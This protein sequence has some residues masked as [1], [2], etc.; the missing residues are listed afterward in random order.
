M[1]LSTDIDSAEPAEG[2]TASESVFA[3]IYALILNGALRPGET[4]KES[5][6]SE[7]FNVSRGPVREAVN[8]L[9]GLGLV[10]KQAYGRARVSELTL[11]TV[12]E[13]FQ[14]REVVEGLA[15]RLAATT[16]STEELARLYADFKADADGTGSADFDLHVRIA[17]LSGNSYVERL[18]CD[19]LSYQLR[20]YRILS[21]NSG[22]RDTAAT[23]HWQILRAMRARD[24]ELAESLMRAHIAHATDQLSQILGEAAPEAAR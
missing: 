17:K 9:R 11:K 19:E 21:G 5:V 18:Y 15:V 23:E 22:R 12:R 14:L 16:A 1:Q 13:I 7:R 20:R 4:I 6:L 24:G 8:R 10:E 2:S 3:Q